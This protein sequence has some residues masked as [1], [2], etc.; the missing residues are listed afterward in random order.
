MPTTGFAL[1]VLSRS[2]TPTIT[3]QNQS[4]N[5]PGP[6]AHILKEELSVVHRR[7]SERHPGL[8]RACPRASARSCVCMHGIVYLYVCS[9]HT[10]VHARVHTTHT[11]PAPSNP[12]VSKSRLSE[13]KVQSPG[14][15]SQP[16]KNVCRF[17]RLRETCRVGSVSL[18]PR[19]SGPVSHRPAPRCEGWNSNLQPAGRL[20]E[21][22][23]PPTPF[24]AGKGRASLGVTPASQEEACLQ[25]HPHPHL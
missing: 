9:P 12:S 2:T 18:S 19:G 20:P 5:T 16:S 4:I 17:P 11:Q 3:I 13:M 7:P 8:L 23:C 21:R 14:T 15:E 24:L 22:A 1:H 6:Q 25:A 10:R